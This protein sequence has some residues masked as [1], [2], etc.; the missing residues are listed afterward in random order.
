M[1]TKLYCHLVALGQR[2][3]NAVID[4]G[5]SFI[6][7][8]VAVSVIPNPR[9]ALALLV[10]QILHIGVLS[11][12]IVITAGAFIG[13]VL[14]LQGYTILVDFGSEQS[15]GQLVALSLVRE[16][17]P[18]V[19]ALLFA[20]RAGSAVTAEIAMMKITEQLTT[21]EVMG[22]NTAH[23]II[24]PRFWAGVI[25]MPLL[26]AIFNFAGIASG[27]F[28][29]IDILSVDAASYWMNMVQSVDFVEDV[30]GGLFK[31]LVFA[32]LIMWI[33][34]YQG[35]SVIP[36]TEGIAF[37][38]TRTVVYSSF[39]ILGMDFVLTAFMFSNL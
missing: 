7:L 8:C 12:L 16:L 28:I 38:T 39:V 6:L 34:V 5:E 10:K 15:V 9:T 29:T 23:R 3:S 32:V 33:A 27:A 25:C 2:F 14:G 11:L 37:A 20:G 17:G 21:L 30:G 4:I 26:V 18:V 35:Y 19:T 1:L 24:A 36:T 22:I 13:L 31:A